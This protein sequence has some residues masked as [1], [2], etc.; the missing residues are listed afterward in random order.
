MK[1][2]Q[3]TDYKHSLF[4]VEPVDTSGVEIVASNIY[5]GINYAVKNG[6]LVTILD[7]TLANDSRSLW[8]ALKGERTPSA[9]DLKMFNDENAAQ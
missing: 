2:S 5:R 7:S 9:N 3:L 4:T 1:L 6:K 8:Y